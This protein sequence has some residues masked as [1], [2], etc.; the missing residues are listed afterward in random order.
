MHVTEELSAVRV[1]A[2]VAA[3]MLALVAED[4]ADGRIKTRLDSDNNFAL[5]A[6]RMTQ[7]IIIATT[8]VQSIKPSEDFD[9]MIEG[10]IFSGSDPDLKTLGGGLVSRI[11][12]AERFPDA[13]LSDDLVESRFDKLLALI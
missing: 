6:I 10:R 8:L 5:R 13:E 7:E 11:A 2:D 1:D 4:Q 12:A 9:A 3:Q